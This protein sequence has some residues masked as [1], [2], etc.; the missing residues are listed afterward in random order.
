MDKKIKLL[1]IEDDLFLLN[2]YASKFE[3]EGFDV[4]LAEDGEKGWKTTIKEVPD[5]ILLDIMMPKM[6]GFEVLEKLK[7]D[8]RVSRIPVILLTNL[9]Q[10]DE[11]ER[12]MNLGAADFLIKAHFRPS[13]VV[14]KIKKLLNLE[15]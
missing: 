14:E 9:S 4:V 12:A 3:L 8:D 11:I 15:Q 1:I 10:K 5:I 13:E 6:N 2:M 7:S